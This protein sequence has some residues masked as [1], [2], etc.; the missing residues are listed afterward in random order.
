MLGRIPV[1]FRSDASYHS[2]LFLSF[3]IASSLPI[4]DINRTNI[5]Q[6]LRLMFRMRIEPAIDV[7]VH[8]GYYSRC[9]SSF[10]SDY[11]MYKFILYMLMKREISSTVPTASTIYL[12][13]NINNKTK[14]YSKKLIDLTF[15]FYIILLLFIYFSPFGSY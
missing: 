8:S 4:L 5:L 14:T 13:C 2:F 10:V 3:S 1:R 7:D 6:R 15:Y 9:G 11:T 12:D